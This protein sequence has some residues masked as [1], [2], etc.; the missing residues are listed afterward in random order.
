[1][2][3]HNEKYYKH[4]FKKWMSVYNKVQKKKHLA[5]LQKIYSSQRKHQLFTL[6]MARTSESMKSKIDEAQLYQMHLHAV[7][8]K[9]FQ[10]LNVRRIEMKREKIMSTIIAEKHC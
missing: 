5:D 6:W 1:M 8:R 9:V 7:K 10:F 4:F 3:I 2:Q